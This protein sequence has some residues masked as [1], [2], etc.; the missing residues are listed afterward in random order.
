MQNE[1]IEVTFT[2]GE[3]QDCEILGT[4]Q[5]ENED[6]IALIPESGTDDV[7]IYGF[8]EHENGFELIDITER[9]LFDKAVEAF[10]DIIAEL[11]ANV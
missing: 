7:Y 10:Y 2:T 1:V 4:F 3:I 9:N 11:V 5:V 8:K 6:F